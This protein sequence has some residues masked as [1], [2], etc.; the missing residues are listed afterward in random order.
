MIKAADLIEMCAKVCEDYSNER[1]HAYKRGDINGP[2]R[3][4]P[5][6]QGESDAASEL[7]DRI[8]ALIPQL[9]DGVVCEAEPEVFMHPDGSEFAWISF[10]D[11]VPLYRAKEATK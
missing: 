10:G 8:R 3:A 5:H 1:W 9:G 7:A 6:V 11:D 4:N 2:D